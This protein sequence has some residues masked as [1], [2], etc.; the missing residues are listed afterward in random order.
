MCACSV[1]EQREKERE[2]LK[3][4]PHSFQTLMVD[5]VS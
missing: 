1:E 5:S 4:A 3:Q 2:N